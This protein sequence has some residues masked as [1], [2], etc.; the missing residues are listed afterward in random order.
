M[1]NIVQLKLISTI[2]WKKNIQLLGCT[3]FWDSDP[4]L[5]QSW[6][7]D[8]LCAKFILMDNRK[9]CSISSGTSCSLVTA[10]QLR[11]LL[12]NERNVT[13]YLFRLGS[14]FHIHHGWVALYGD[15]KNHINRSCASAYKI[16]KRQEVFFFQSAELF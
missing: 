13:L 14:F 9:F 1:Y 4:D 12:E 10:H 11:A 5:P 15:A 2:L 3:P 8:N 16:N 6:S 7:F